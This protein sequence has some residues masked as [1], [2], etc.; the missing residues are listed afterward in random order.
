MLAIRVHEELI[1]DVVKH[2]NIEYNNIHGRLVS[3]SSLSQIWNILS[4]LIGAAEIGTR[5]PAALR[6]NNANRPTY[7]T[8]LA[9]LTPAPSR[10]KTP[11]S[12][13]YSWGRCPTNGFSSRLFIRQKRNSVCYARCDRTRPSTAASTA[14]R[15]TVSALL[16]ATLQTAAVLCSVQPTAATSSASDSII[17]SSVSLACAVDNSSPIRS[18]VESERMQLQSVMPTD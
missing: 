17:L 7:N 4:A 13:R 5:A 8:A 1:S 18:G 14:L 10:S 9:L 15:S 11:D 12:G 6:C 3:V 2:I 16:R